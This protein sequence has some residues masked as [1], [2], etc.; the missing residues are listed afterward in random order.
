M[1]VDDGDD[2][3][4][5]SFERGMRPRLRQTPPRD[6]FEPCPLGFLVAAVEATGRGEADDLDRNVVLQELVRS[7]NRLCNHHSARCYR[8]CAPLL[9]E[10]TVSS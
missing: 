6:H 10:D 2:G 9:P 5:R 1:A 3:R 4:V 7:R 8:D